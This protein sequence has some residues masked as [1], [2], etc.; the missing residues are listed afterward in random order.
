MEMEIARW[1]RVGESRSDVEA[2]L[3]SEEPTKVGDDVSSFKDGG[4]SVVVASVERHEPVAMSASYGQDAE[5]CDDVPMPRKHAASFD[6]VCEREAK[7]ARLSRPSEAS[8]AL[9][10]PAS[11]VVG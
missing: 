5:R 7:Q 3:E 2:E 11:G 8:S 4:Q 1:V 9:S 6:T 10:P